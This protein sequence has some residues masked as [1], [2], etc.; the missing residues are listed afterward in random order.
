[1]TGRAALEVKTLRTVLL[2]RFHENMLSLEQYRDSMANDNSK[3]YKALKR[4][5]RSVIENELTQRQKQVVMLYYYEGKTVLEIGKILNIN[6]ST[7]SRHLRKARDRIERV[8]K[9][10]YFPVWKEIEQ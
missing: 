3:Q 9:Y 7:V 4:V 8:L 1:M 2:D 5:L 10:G 6:K